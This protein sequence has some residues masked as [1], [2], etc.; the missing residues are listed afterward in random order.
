M[1]IEFPP[2]RL[3]SKPSSNLGVFGP[4]ARVLSATQA[5]ARVNLAALGTS[6]T[7]PDLWGMAN[8][9]Y[10]MLRATDRRIFDRV[11]FT[12]VVDGSGAGASGMWPDRR[13]R[14]RAAIY[15][16]RNRRFRF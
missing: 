15:A 4:A 10:A 2:R 9:A 16:M 7:P 14:A 6:Y 11:L 3:G 13:R 5:R 1:P 12:G 8:P